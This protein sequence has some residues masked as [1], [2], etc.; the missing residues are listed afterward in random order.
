MNDHPD[1]SLE[2]LMQMDNRKVFELSKY[3]PK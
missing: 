2:Q 1:T 3:K